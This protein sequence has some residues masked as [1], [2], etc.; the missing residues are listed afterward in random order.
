MDVPRASWPER[1]GL[2][3]LCL[4]FAGCRQSEAPLPPAQAK[5][6]SPEQCVEPSA[7]TILERKTYPLAR[8]L[9]I[10]VNKSHLAK[11][12]ALFHF[13]RFY[14]E[15]APLLAKEV[16]YFP[17]EKSLYQKD[18]QRLYEAVSGTEPELPSSGKMLADG[19][20]TVYL[21]TQAV[22][23]EFGKAHP[24]IQPQVAFSGT[25][26]GFKKFARGETDINGASRP[27]SSAE[28]EQCAKE[29]IDYLEFVVAVDAL[30]IIVHR[31]NDWCDCLSIAQLREIWQPGSK[32]ER[33][34]QLDPRWPDRRIE[35]F[36]ADTDS[37]TF[38]YFT[39]R[40]VGQAKASRTDYMPSADDNLIIRGVAGEKY[41][42]GYVPYGYYEQNR[43]VVKAVRVAP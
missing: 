14:L 1:L 31:E 5:H 32:I 40:V 16:G 19:S 7:A 2:V 28:K 8:P 39:E 6:P 42:L 9:Y 13:L 12:P 41:G 27:I 26:G 30:T 4:F 38:D 11:N 33:W 10:Y 25:G 23:E 24:G 37:G 20:S 3:C 35:L 18:L 43:D 21:L 22:A 15:R 29:G 17:L 36:G 34:S